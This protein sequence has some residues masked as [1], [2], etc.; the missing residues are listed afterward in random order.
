MALQIIQSTGNSAKHYTFSN[1]T[2]ALEKDG[3]QS[4]LIGFF[5]LIRSNLLISELSLHSPK[6][7]FYKIS[8]IPLTLGALATFGKE[9]G[10]NYIK[11]HPTPNSTQE[12]LFNKAAHLL[13]DIGNGSHKIL[14]HSDKLFNTAFLVNSIALIAFGFPLQGAICLI[15][16][17][18]ILLKRGQYLPSAFDH[19]INPIL[20]ISSLTASL[21]SPSGIIIKGLLIFLDLLNI[22]SQIMNT[23]FVKSKLSE[24]II[25]PFAGMHGKQD[26]KYDLSYRIAF[27]SINKNYIYNDEAGKLLSNECNSSLTESAEELFYELEVQ[28]QKSGISLSADLENGLSSLKTCAITGSSGDVSPADVEI[29]KKL[30]KAHVF[31]L[32]NDK[33]N[34]DDKIKEFATLG[35]SCAEGWTKEITA[36][37]FPHTKDIT[38]AVHNILSK[39]RGEIIKE[40][41]RKFDQQNGNCLEK[42][43]GNNG[44]HI[45]N[46]MQIA[47]WQRFRSYEAE[48]QMQLNPISPL[49]ALFLKH[50]LKSQQP[51]T[52]EGYYIGATIGIKNQSLIFSISELFLSVYRRSYQRIF[53]DEQGTID[54]IYDAIKPQYRQGADGMFQIHREISWIAVQ[55][56]LN[57]MQNKNPT[58][59]LSEENWIE[60]DL[61]GKQT[62]SKEGVKHL[63]IHLGILI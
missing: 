48:V 55:E 60:T 53:Y 2:N 9:A 39:R 29:F 47:L 34:F 8:L 43:G 20:I 40:E 36:L 59:D 52:L 19:I 44:V 4:L 22:I 57:D 38:W 32:L 27:P 11:N 18:A 26:L 62:L 37:H 33:I 10:E 42:A 51:S 6:L 54:A 31:S 45:T 21:T 23:K 50:C 13:R 5:G 17:T 16:L 7:G 25:N 28:I 30:I 24:F 49:Q 61:Q 1:V 15:G 63:L 14:H 56:W 3:K 35:N 12:V 46:T 41:I 58:R